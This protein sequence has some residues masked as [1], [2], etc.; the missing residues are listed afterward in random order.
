MREKDL[1]RIIDNLKPDSCLKNRI[2]DAV[3]SKDRIKV[4]KRPVFIPVVMMLLICVNLGVMAVFFGND[5][6]NSRWTKTNIASQDESSFSADMSGVTMKQQIDDFCQE[7]AKNSYDYFTYYNYQSKDPYGETPWYYMVREYFNDT[8]YHY[9]GNVPYRR[10]VQTVPPEAVDGDYGLIYTPHEYMVM[11]DGAGFEKE[12]IV[13]VVESVYD[14][15]KG[16]FF[17]GKRFKVEFEDM[18]QHDFGSEDFNP[19][20]MLVFVNDFEY[21][22]LR[23]VQI[24]DYSADYDTGI[25]SVDFYGTYDVNL[26]FHESNWKMPENNDAMA[27]PYLAGTEYGMALNIVKNYGLDCEFMYPDGYDADDTGVT[28]VV[29]GVSLQSERVVSRDQKFYV[30]LYN[31]DDVAYNDPDVAEAIET[32]GGNGLPVSDEVEDEG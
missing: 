8:V 13:Y 24:I 17:D 1:Y 28:F 14:I 30:Y 3:E 21:E 18:S 31:P 2:S 26:N 22:C 23:G 9:D 19:F 27:M 29:S 25:K 4:E 32:E 15:T 5:R 7:I 11:Y 6:L 16:S 10:Y 20:D 12:N